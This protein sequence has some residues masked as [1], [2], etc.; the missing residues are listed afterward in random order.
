MTHRGRLIFSLD[1]SSPARQTFPF[2]P[3]QITR[4][5]RGPSSELSYRRFRIIAGVVIVKMPRHKCQAS[6]LSLIHPNQREAAR[7]IH[8]CF[9]TYSQG[10]ALSSRIR[11]GMSS[12]RPDY[13]RCRLRLLLDDTSR[14][15]PFAFTSSFIT[16]CA[17]RLH[18]FGC[19]SRSLSFS[20][21]PNTSRLYLSQ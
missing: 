15:H 8:R 4:N 21:H 13:K 11:Q 20:L 6:N 17:V 19:L 1:P 16:R 14:S 9:E 5:W 7:N 3:V 18:S 10:Y 2:T 12:M